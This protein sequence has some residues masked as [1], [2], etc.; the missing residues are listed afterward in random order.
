MRFL[1][2]MKPALWSGFCILWA[3][4]AVVALFWPLA[5]QARDDGRYAQSDN[6]GWFKSLMVPNTGG[7]CCDQSDCKA[8]EMRIAGDHYEAA[9]PDGTF[10]PIP[11]E[12]VIYNKGNPLG[13]PVLCALRRRDG[14]QVLCF[15]PGG[16]V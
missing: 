7:S 8:T 14:W 4:L 12:A 2:T 11:P 6:H 3:A 1:A 13:E 15:I 16:G 10:I 5:V 9:A